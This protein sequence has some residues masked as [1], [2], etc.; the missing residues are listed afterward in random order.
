MKLL[1]TQLQKET[2]R[3]AA[4]EG[5][6]AG[7]RKGLKE[8]WAICKERGVKVGEPC[9]NEGG[10]GGG[11]A[12]RQVE[13]LPRREEGGRE[14]GRAVWP[15]LLLYPEYLTSDF[16]EAVGEEEMLALTLAVVLPEDEEEEGGREGGAA[17]WDRRGD[18]KCSQV[19]IYFQAMRE[20][21]REGE[22]LGS[23]EEYVKSVER[24]YGLCGVGGDDYMR[25]EAREEREEEL[26]KKNVWRDRGEYWVNVHVACSLMDVLKHGDCVVPATCPTLHVFVRDSEAHQAF[27]AET[28]GKIRELLPKG[29]MVK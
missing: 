13:A 9:W 17:P 18:Y 11:E 5:R 7:R 21:G 24:F 16:V 10:Q 8:A 4:R 25:E 15:L 20:G 3:I 29:L 12:R 22:V 6:K 14:G 2:D 1:K 23:E 28:A 27:L 26:A 19:E